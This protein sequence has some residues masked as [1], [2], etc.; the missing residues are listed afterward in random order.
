MYIG[1]DVAP[2]SVTKLR[3]FSRSRSLRI[4]YSTVIDAPTDRVWDVLRSH[5]RRFLLLASSAALLSLFATPASQFLN[6]FLRT[7]LVLVAPRDGVVMGLPTID[8]IFKT[9]TEQDVQ[10][11][12]FCTIGD[13]K[14][15]RVLVKRV[16][17]DLP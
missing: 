12:P 3:I 13:P 7:K 8:E 2:E 10:Q 1:L 14:K 15:L 9:W 5:R 11:K 6:E 17:G 4:R 16:V